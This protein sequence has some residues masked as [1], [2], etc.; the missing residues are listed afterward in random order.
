MSPFKKSTMKGDCSKGK[1][2]MIDLDSF[3]PK[4]KKTRSSTGVYDDTCFRSYAAYQAYL[5]HFKGVPMLIERVIEQG[6][7]LDMNIP[8]WFASKGWNYLLSNLEDPYEEL[9]KEF[10][11][12]PSSLWMN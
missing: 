9:V 4:S 2:T 8:K 10:L 7:L 5:H 1:E 3:S 11:Q 12:M 6:S